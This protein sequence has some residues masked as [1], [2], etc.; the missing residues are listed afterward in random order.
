MKKISFISLFLLVS[1]LFAFAIYEYTYNQKVL[2]IINDRNQS[3]TYSEYFE[4]YFNKYGEFPKELSDVFNFYIDK[5]E[6]SIFINDFFTDPFTPDSL[7]IY[8]PRRSNDGTVIGFVLISRG[9]DKITSNKIPDFANINSQIDKMRFYNFDNIMHN[10]MVPSPDLLQMRYFPF[11]SFFGRSDLYISS[12]TIEGL[13][14]HSISILLKNKDI[15]NNEKLLGWIKERNYKN[16]STLYP[17]LL[18]S[19]IPLRLLNYN[20]IDS[21][22]NSTLIITEGSY[23][24]HCSMMNDAIAHFQE[25]TNNSMVGGRI[26]SIDIQNKIIFVKDCIILSMP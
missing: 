26:D 10:G 21:I 11:V 15:S 13:Y 16:D 5:P 3:I 25:L 9:P 19:I 1:V 14:I 22:D 8:I 24:F 20:K 23:N 12:Y 18:K 4:S 17:I 7:L 6:D 2:R